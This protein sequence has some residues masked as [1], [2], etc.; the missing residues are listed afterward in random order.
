MSALEGRI[1]ALESLLSSIKN[2]AGG[3]RDSIVATVDLV[4]HLPAP[5]HRALA[6]MCEPEYNMDAKSRAS[7]WT[8]SKEGLTS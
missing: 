4:D 5:T 7:C 6:M 3:E 8:F 2:A 1:A